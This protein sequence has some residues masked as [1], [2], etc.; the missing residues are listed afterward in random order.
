[1]FSFFL[2]SYFNILSHSQGL[3]GKFLSVAQPGG[4]GAWQSYL[5]V[6]P[7]HFTHKNTKDHLCLHKEGLGENIATV[8]NSSEAFTPLWGDTQQGLQDTNPACIRM[9][10]PSR[11]VISPST[12]SLSMSVCASASH[13]TNVT[14]ASTRHLL[15]VEFH[16]FFHACQVSQG[17]LRGQSV[18]AAL[19]F[20]PCCLDRVLVCIYGQTFTPHGKY[21][22]FHFAYWDF[23]LLLF[24]HKAVQ[25][26]LSPL[27]LCFRLVAMD[28]NH[29]ESGDASSCSV[30]CLTSMC[31]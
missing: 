31:W 21:W 14:R 25:A 19:C 1:M 9:C 5:P 3:N 6:L 12:L 11:A 28:T 15:S 29:R 22:D 4:R 24:F 8:S 23:F 10:A 13:Q 18:L 16:T 2:M 17:G 26:L 27:A 7:W 30:H 20:P